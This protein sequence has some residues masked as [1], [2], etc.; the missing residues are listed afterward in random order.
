MLSQAKKELHR[1][2]LELDGVAVLRNLVKRGID[3]PGADAQ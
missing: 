2:P 3:A 1:P